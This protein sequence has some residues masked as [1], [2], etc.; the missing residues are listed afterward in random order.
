[1]HAQVSAPESWPMARIPDLLASG[2]TL[3][4]EFS[5]PRDPDAQRRLEQAQQ[6][7]ARL[8]P[9]FISVTYGPSGTTR[10]PTEAIV[11]HAQHALG[12]TAMP[13]LTCVSHTTEEIGAILDRYAADGVENLLALHGDL[14]EGTDEMPPGHFSR[15]IDLVAFVRE[16]VP[17]AIGVAIHPEGHP[18][19][20]TLEED[21]AHQAAK[22]TTADFG[23]TQFFFRV[24]HY[25]RYIEDLTSRGVDTP[26]IP[27]VMP[28][29]N[30]ELVARFAAMNNTE[31]PPEIRSRL[32]AAGDDLR[33]RREIGVEVASEL[34]R[35]LLDAGAPGLHIYTLN[36]SQAA[37]EVVRNLELRPAPSV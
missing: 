20:A 18:A 24:E 37:S 27:G 31:F 17:F 11:S 33:A 2:P 29:T 10:G 8:E 28:P 19:A 26:V 23:I 6:R 4:F 16:R 21:R 14:P 9:S 12:V 22:L 5:A 35:R 30:P 3:S 25:E 34:S 1:M 36:F 13:H 7:L 15:A 32:E